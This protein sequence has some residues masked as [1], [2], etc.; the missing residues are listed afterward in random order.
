MLIALVFCLL[1]LTTP[2]SAF[3]GLDSAGQTCVI[4]SATATPDCPADQPLPNQLDEEEIEF[5]ALLRSNLDFPEV[6]QN[7]DL[8]KSYTGPDPD[9]LKRP[10]RA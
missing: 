8:N 10:P 2:Y 1:S 7:F 6:S 5:E 9:L 3:A 4:T